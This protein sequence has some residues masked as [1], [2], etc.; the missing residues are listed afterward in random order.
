[1]SRLLAA[2][3]IAAAAHLLKDIA[4][5]DRRHLNAAA[6]RRDCLVE[7]DV[8]HHR[9]HDCVV[10]QMPRA[11][12][13]RRTGDENMIPVEQRSRLIET[14]A[15]VRVAVVGDTDVR[16]AFEHR[17]AQGVQMR[18][19]AAVVD[20]HPVRERVDHL[21]VGTEAAQHLRHRLI[22]CT[23]RT[24]E[25]DPHP[26]KPLGTRAHH[27]VDVLVEEVIAILHHADILSR[28]TRLMVAVLQLADKSL[29][30]VFYGIGQL[31][32][33]AAKEFDA[34]IGERVVG[35]RDHNAR[36]HLMLT[37]E[38]GNRRRRH[39]PREESG[40]A[41]RADAR[42]QR[43]LEHLA[44][45]TRIAPDQNAW[46]HLGVCSEIEC[47]RASKLISQLRCEL[48]IR[49]TAYAIR[50]KKSHDNSLL[51]IFSIICC[52]PECADPH[53]VTFPLSSP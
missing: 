11:H 16:P 32:A 17:T 21:D 25:D 47:R 37:C 42:R 8:R 26:I 52:A 34:V 27:V 44:R 7:S 43:R 29:Q 23:V 40:S 20:V 2:D 36:V 51:C 28:W 13:L 24:V 39:D 22:R 33:V 49:H 3:R 38:I 41:R 50:P 5:A 10:R 45:D 31:V 30:L 18:R 53:T 1:M 4:V 12:H 14:E 35:C 6:K 19:A 48:R 9:R 46:P 15:A